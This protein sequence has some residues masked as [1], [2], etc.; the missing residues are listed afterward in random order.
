MTEMTS[1]SKRKTAILGT[2]AQDFWWPC[3]L[4]S[5]LL[6]FASFLFA[7]C[8]GSPNSPSANG[9]LRLMLTDAP[10]DVAHVNIFFTEAEVKPVDGPPQK[11]PITLTPNPVDL[12]GLANVDVALAGGAVPAGDY[13]WIRLNIDASKSNVVL[14]G[15]TVE[16]PLKTPSSEVKILGGFAVATG[17]ATTLTL[18]FDAKAS[19]VKE[20]NG[21]WLLKPVIIIKN[22]GT[23]PQS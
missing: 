14:E 21:Q 7:S 15:S 23:T 12:I 13:E 11:L 4:A 5:L 1:Q 6:V 17:G 10:G 2:F 3:L 9:N 19:L 16:L 8:S 20:G 22:K 18:D